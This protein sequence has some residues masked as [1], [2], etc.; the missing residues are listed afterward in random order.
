[1]TDEKD[2]NFTPIRELIGTAYEQIESQYNN[3]EH[4]KGLSSGFY[5]LDNILSGFLPS[6]LIVVA[7]R[8]SMGKT[9]FCYNIALESALKNKKNV[10]LFSTESSNEQ[11]VSRLL[12]IEAEVDTM[13]LKTVHMQREDWERLT[14]AMESFA[15]SNLCI[16]TSARLSVLEVENECKKM[17]EEHGSLDLVIIDYLQLMDVEQ[18]AD[19]IWGMTEIARKLKI[20]A[21]ELNIP[22]VVSSQI[23][24]AVETRTNKRPTLIDLSESGAIEQVAD[25]IVFIYR[26]EYYEP[27]N[28]NIKGLAELIIAKHRSGPT[29]TIE[30][31]FRNNITKFKNKTISSVF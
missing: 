14:K 21:R 19:R 23:S 7:S 3:C 26:K 15:E 29:D 10:L 9:S 6:D 31:L 2:S 22:I 17:I 20:L 8:P 24:R 18:G 13:R 12:C 30:L 28:F 16:N 4:T 25:I 5:D 1:M 27:D 11:V